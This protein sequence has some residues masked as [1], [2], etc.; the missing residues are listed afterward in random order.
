MSPKIIQGLKEMAKI[1]LAQPVIDEAINKLSKEVSLLQ[2]QP[3]LAVI[4]VGDNPASKIYVTKKLEFCKK[5]GANCK[6]HHLDE[7]IEPNEFLKTVASLS[8]A[9]DV[10]GLLIQLPLPKQLSQIDIGQLI[11]KEKDVDGFHPLNTYEIYR[12]SKKECLTPCTPLGIVR[13]LKHYG[14]SFEGKSALIIGRS[15]IVGKP[16]SLLLN[17][18]NATTTLAHSKTTNLKELSKKADIIFSA[19]GDPKFLTNEFF[20]DDK[21]QWVVDV[22]ISR[23]KHNKLSGDVDFDHVKEHVHA[24]TPVPGGIGPMTILSLA[25]NL[26]SAAKKQFSR[27][28]L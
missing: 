27:K 14:Y 15:T 24:I 8:G 25:D 18:L 20:R 12:N 9:P 16:L 13:L 22:G 5:I 6:I 1:L 28:S 7:S 23:D 11:P 4:L 26:V 10:N 19:T 21:T 17:N 2:S 3:Y